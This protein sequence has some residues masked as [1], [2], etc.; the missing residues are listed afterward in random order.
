MS[1]VS[2]V[3]RCYHC[4]AVLQTE[5][6]NEA[7]YITKE[8]IDRYPKGLLLC[9]NCFK[10][11]RYNE[12]PK[13]NSSFDL[14]YQQIINKIKKDNALVVYVVD[15][16]SFEG[17]FISKLNESLKGINVLAAA[18]KIDLLPSNINYHKL[19][20]YVSNTL[21]NAK[22]SV[23]DTCLVSSNSG[24]N[25]DLMYNKIVSLAKNKDVYFLGANESGKTNLINELL[26]QYQNKTN[27][28]IVTFTFPKTN[29]RCMKI[30][31]NEK[32]Y[33]YET[34]GFFVDNSLLAKVN[35]SVAHYII[36]RNTIK[37]HN[38]TL[39]ANNCLLF[40]GLAGIV[41]LSKKTTK[42]SVYISNQ[43]EL[44]KTK[45][46]EK[47][48]L[49]LKKKKFKLMSEN[50]SSSTD[51]DAFDIQID[52]DKY[53]TLGILGLGFITLKGEKQL[54]RILVPKGV[55]IFINDNKIEYVK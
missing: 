25:I 10:N 33:I 7:G 1:E 22:L 19:A 2:K 28:P 27:K 44:I 34:P 39:L 16:F 11:E 45:D 29:L 20:E 9:D 38:L 47:T 3:N 46:I 23:I 18:N 12:S 32:N 48:M 6:E 52:E 5:N 55:Y 8:I 36:P 35:K 49:L 42:L 26:K 50:V 41:L 17:S 4:G 53:L 24:Y 54:F 30:P 37:V 31:L 21:K 40:S 15:I 51:F 13:E 14:G 43:V